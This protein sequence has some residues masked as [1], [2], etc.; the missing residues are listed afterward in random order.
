VRVDIVP[1]DTITIV[2]RQFQDMKSSG[3]DVKCSV[4][5]RGRI[6]GTPQPVAELRKRLTDAGLS[7]DCIRIDDL[8]YNSN[9]A[10][11]FGCLFV[12]GIIA[13]SLAFSKGADMAMV[14]P[15]VAFAVLAIWCAYWFYNR[16][17]VCNFKVVCKNS[18]A[19]EVAHKFIAENSDF[20]VSSTEWRYEIDAGLL[21]DWAEKCIERANVLLGKSCGQTEC[22]T[23]W[24]IFIRG[25]ARLAE[26]P[27]FIG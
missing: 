24:R 17:T 1:A 22:E 19:V 26:K 8:T 27:V 10:E 7:S 5:L 21:T 9:T 20:Q 4:L 3:A 12:L 16:T 18:P 23:G 11:A 2:E 13:G 25:I 14:V 15:A 6:S